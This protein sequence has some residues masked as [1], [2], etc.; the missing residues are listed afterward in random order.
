MRPS[1]RATADRLK[2]YALRETLNL[3]E[4]ACLAHGADPE[5]VSDRAW[6]D[7]REHWRTAHGWMRSP[8]PVEVAEEIGARPEM[9]LGEQIGSTL[10]ALCIATA[11]NLQRAVPIAQA[12]RL[13][14]AL[15]L[16]LP[17]ELG[18]AETPAERHGAPADLE[19]EALST[20]GRRGAE[21]RHAETNAMKER[22]RAFY[23]E[24]RARMT[25]D[26]AADAFTKLEPVKF[27]TV[28][29]WLKGQ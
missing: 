15:A 10:K 9:I 29:D 23:A 26:A 20:L 17:G 5:R 4:L 2:L 8:T 6:L 27:R 14:G 19:R 25:K 22:A 7:V 1:E 18:H 12:R 11:G 24:R 16:D 21:A 13:L 28:R 3:Y